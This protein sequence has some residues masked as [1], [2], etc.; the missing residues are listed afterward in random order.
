MWPSRKTLVNRKGYPANLYAAG[1]LDQFRF[2]IF[3]LCWGG[4]L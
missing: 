1:V 3:V 2:P 4:A